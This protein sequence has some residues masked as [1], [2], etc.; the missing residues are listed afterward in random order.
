MNRLVTECSCSQK[1]IFGGYFFVLA[2]VLNCTPF[3]RQLTNGVFSWVQNVFQ[4]SLKKK[5]LNFF[6]KV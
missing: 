5:L 6:N 4:K 2:P 3:G 1:A